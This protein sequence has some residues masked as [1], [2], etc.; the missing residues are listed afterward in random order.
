[1]LSKKI[2]IVVLALGLKAYAQNTNSGNLTGNIETTFQYL[3][4]DTIIGADVPSEKGL[5]NSYMNVFYTYGNF[6]TGMRIESY[7]PR[8]NGYPNRFDGT[9]LGMRYV[10][11]ANDKIDI[12]LGHFYE[13]FGSGLLFRSYEDR[14]LGY[15]NVIDGMRMI[16]RPT[17][18]VVLKGVYGS[19]RLDFKEG[20]VL[21][22]S[23]I[24]RGIDGEV[25]LN[26]LLPKLKD[27][28]LDISLGA[29]FVSK[30]QEDDNDLLNLPEN[31]GSYGG[32]FDM[33]YKKFS[34]NAEYVVKENDP[35]SDNGYIYNNGHTALI[36]FNYSTKGLG[37][38]LS[39]K[40][41]DNMSFRSDRTQALQDVL[42]NYLP[43]L[44]KTHTY[45]LVASLYPYAT[46]L[47]GEIAYQAE[48]L[49]TFP[50]KSKIG[51]KYGT[52]ING[53]FS[54]AYQP[55]QDFSGFSSSDSTGIMY[56][57]TPFSASS[58]LFWQD[59]NFSIS[60]KLSK[61]FSFIL[62]Y[63]NIKLNNDVAK[64]TETEDSK[65]IINPNI[66]VADVSYKI[67][68]NHAIRFE[69]QSLT[70][71]HNFSRDNGDWAT[72][73]I[74]YNYKSNW[75][76]GVMD[77]YNYSNPDEALQLHYLIGTIG[78]VEGATRYMVSYGRQRA[79]LFCVGGVCRFVPASNG[80]TFTFTHSF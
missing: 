36:N 48:V 46:Q 42:I 40:S 26:Q 10:G 34:L 4:E 6:K 55:Y 32:R 37:I 43:A 23:G 25:H 18:G 76:F 80:L 28:P 77:Q 39:A 54:T 71:S 64:V 17:D 33:R 66:F 78:Y 15:D 72:A 58:N 59:I 51:G 73:V 67:N 74:E 47:N 62:S 22:S 65:G 24:V 16:V 29:T 63:Y 8:I 30:F 68:R 3:N 79:G 21:K 53:N 12:T 75:V 14:A 35:S 49:Y 2:L 31:V 38:S 27:K 20:R 45:N 1:M 13:Q 61:R 41:T 57:T 69:L 52:T 11:Y 56:K 7:M 9:G 70:N 60:K 50:K 44:N 19:N 5:I